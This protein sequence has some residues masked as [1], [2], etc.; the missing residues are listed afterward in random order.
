MALNRNAL[1]ARLA[2]ELP[3]NGWVALAGLAAA[4][5]APRLAPGQAVR[6]WPGPQ[7]PPSPDLAVVVARRVSD[8]GELEP[9]APADAGAL[10]KAPRLLAV[11]L[12]SDGALPAMDDAAG[13]L[14][15]AGPAPDAPSAEALLAY[16]VLSPWAVLDVEQG[17]FVVRELC[18]GLSARELQEAVT[19]PLAIASD[20]AEMVV[21]VVDESNH[22]MA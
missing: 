17:R 2:S 3:A 18:P 8:R 6:W 19:A 15:E 12:P 16:R 7:A 9:V 22:G 13:S 1:L 21:P 4:E 20:V 11:L 10:A 5:L 14:V